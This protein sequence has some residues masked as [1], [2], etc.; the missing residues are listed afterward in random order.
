LFKKDDLLKL[1]KE[2]QKNVA[3]ENNIKVVLTRKKKAEIIEA[4]LSFQDTAFRN[5]VAEEFK[6]HDDVIEPSRGV[7]EPPYSVTETRSRLIKK[8]DTTEVDYTIKINRIIE[9]E[10]A[11]SAMIDHA[12]KNGDYKKG[13][14]MRIVVS[15]PYFNRDMS[16]Y[17]EDKDT[18]KEY[19]ENILSSNEEIDI[20]QC[21]FHIQISNVPRGQGRVTKIINLAN[22]ANQKMHN[23]NKKQ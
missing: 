4:I 3:K 8:Y 20:T 16:K 6:F 9:V 12:R 7:R 13:D 22:D 17:V 5:V 23:T 21:T 18:L 1:T 11:I 19:I 2:E 14:Q 10:N 15:N